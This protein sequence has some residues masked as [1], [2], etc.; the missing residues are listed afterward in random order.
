MRFFAITLFALL[1]P[2]QA[3]A[4]A[5]LRASDPA[6][7][8]V[9]A[10]P[11]AAVTLTFNEGVAPLVLRLI[12]PDGE[13]VDLDGSA[14]NEKVAIPLPATDAIGTHL[15]SW[16][17]VSSD[18]HPVGGTLTFHVGA[19]ST[20]PPSAENL[21]QAAAQWAAILRLTLTATLVLAVGGAVFVA[22]VDRGE[23][24]AAP[25]RMVLAAA[26]A[27]PV[28]GALL[29]G[30]EGLDLLGLP[31]ADLATSPP[32]RAGLW[33]PITSTVALSAVGAA[34]AARSVHAS[35]GDAQA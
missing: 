22:M 16:R 30:A 15:L 21:S 17:V 14:E 28:A 8:A 11:P 9:V 1:A 32:W 24:G 20:S 7:G 26:V 31:P 12:G 4:H 25:A 35:S 27:T 13:T 33:A 29:I 3:L 19:P 2:V 10:Q 34:L 18:G 5:Q 23:A 6:D